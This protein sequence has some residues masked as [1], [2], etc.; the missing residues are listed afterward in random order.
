MKLLEVP[1]SIRARRGSRLEIAKKKK[2]EKMMK[3][4]EVP[5]SMRARRGSRLEIAKIKKEKQDENVK[6]T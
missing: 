2:K 6:S 5:K 4:L 3:L 1:K